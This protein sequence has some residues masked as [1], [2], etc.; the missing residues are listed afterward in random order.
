LNSFFTNFL[1]PFSYC[2][3]IV[4][5]FIALTRIRTLKIKVLFCYYLIA[6]CL[7]FYASL[8][9]FYKTKG[10]NNWIYNLFFLLTIC[11]FSYYFYQLFYIKQ[12]KYIALFFLTLNVIFFLIVHIVKQQ[13][14]NQVNNYITAFCF[15]SIV[16]YALLYFD[17]VIRNVSEVNILHEFDF[18]LVSGYLLYFLSCFCIILFYKNATIELRKTMWALQNLI[19]F[20]SSVITLTGNLW[21]NYQKKH[22]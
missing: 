14:F 19:L 22:H 15:L 10:D 8:L 2:I 9:A 11:I 7:I 1:E 16:I 4:I 12:K 21:I 5:L 13:F 20:L 17:Q 3:Y 18:W 6:T